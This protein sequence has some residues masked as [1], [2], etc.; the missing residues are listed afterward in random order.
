[1]E[2]SSVSSFNNRLAP[3]TA[4]E[5]WLLEMP[6]YP[7]LIAALEDPPEPPAHGLRRAEIRRP[8][9]GGENS[10]RIKNVLF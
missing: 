5:R 6:Y 2:P 4:P 10:S 9:G 8:Q 7:N 3:T 1:M